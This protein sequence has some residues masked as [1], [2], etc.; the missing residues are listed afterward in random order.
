M[1][2]VFALLSAIFYSFLWILARMSRGMPT[3][4][5]ASFQFIAGPIIL[6][7]ALR[8]VDIPWGEWWWQL[9]LIC[10]VILLPLAMWLLT[11]AVHR[12]EVT[13]IKPLTALS[14]IVTLIVAH[15]FFSESVT[16]IGVLGIL[17][18][19]GGLFFLY[20]GRWSAWKTSGPWLCLAGTFILG[21]NVACLGAV[22][23]RFPSVITLMGFEFASVFFLNGIAAGKSWAGNWWSRRNVIILLLMACV[24]VI[25]DI[26]T[27]NALILGPSPYVVAIKRTS[28]LMTAVIGY[29][30]LRERDQSISRLIIACSLVVCGVILLTI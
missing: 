26:F 14:S 8:T 11:A 6:I 1:W 7:Y 12:T 10:P 16:L 13:L 4:V 3:A 15:S 22:L 19:T 17:I 18:I 29:V 5:V 20:H 27:L 24:V 2:F 30:F 28:V 25:Q 23:S 9:F 21:V